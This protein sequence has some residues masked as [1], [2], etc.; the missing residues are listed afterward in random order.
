MMQETS[1][2]LLTNVLRFVDFK[3]QY[4]LRSIT[5][6]SSRADLHANPSDFNLYCQIF[7][8][9]D[10]PCE[11]TRRKTE[12]SSPFQLAEIKSDV[13]DDAFVATRIRGS[14]NVNLSR[15]FITLSVHEV[16]IQLLTVGVLA[17]L[18]L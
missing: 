17:A 2:F 13:K 10:F 3:G 1:Y 15:R 7:A 5:A 9:S 4:P 12:I 11:I 14:E 8:K 6:H 18:I 16:V